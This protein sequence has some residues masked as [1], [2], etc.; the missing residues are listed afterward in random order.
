MRALL[1]VGPMLVAGLM[2]VSVTPAAEADEAVVIR[3]GVMCSSPRAL[4]ALT[5]PN[6]D[7]R[8]H[9]GVS[10]ERYLEIARTGGCSDLQIG[11]KLDVSK[12]FRN[13]AVVTLVGN[14]QEDD[15]AIFLAPLIDLEMGS[16]SAEVAE[17]ASATGGDRLPGARGPKADMIM[18]VPIGMARAD[19][20]KTHGDGKCV[21]S[22]DGGLECYYSGTNKADCPGQYACYATIYEFLHGTLV[23]FHTQLV[24]QSDWVQLY[25]LTLAMFASPMPTTQAWGNA[26]SFSTD[27]GVLESAHKMGPPPSWHVILNYRPDNT[28]IMR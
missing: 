5:L 25:R 21:Q 11:Q 12:S 18:D 8:T 16:P 2:L 27:V 6:G 17:A 3:P 23:A 9:R 14:R 20:A 4:A 10:I 22:A 15:A 24:S 19:F 13:T 26:T 28:P 1:T 7:S